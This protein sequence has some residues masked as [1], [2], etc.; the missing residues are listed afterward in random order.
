MR[1][2]NISIFCCNIK[3]Q[4]TSIK[5]KNTLLCTVIFLTTED[6]GVEGRIE[7]RNLRNFCS[8]MFSG[9]CNDRGGRNEK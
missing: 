1:Y 3:L 5:I 4:T 2:F 7:Y 9:N 8:L 6:T